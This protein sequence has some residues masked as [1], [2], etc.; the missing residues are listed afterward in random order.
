MKATV[1]NWIDHLLEV[2]A[3]LSFEV[4]LAQMIG[5]QQAVLGSPVVSLVVGISFWAWAYGTRYQI[6]CGLVVMLMGLQQCC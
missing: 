2:V 1:Q 6:V 4:V 5:W 3:G